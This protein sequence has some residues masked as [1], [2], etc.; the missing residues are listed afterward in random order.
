M[1]PITSWRHM[2]LETIRLVPR[3]REKLEP[4]GFHLWRT[5]SLQLLS[6][7]KHGCND[8]ETN[9]SHCRFLIFFIIS[10]YCHIFLEHLCEKDI[11]W[12][13]HTWTHFDWLIA[14][15]FQEICRVLLMPP[16]TFNSAFLYI[17]YHSMV[18]VQHG[19]CRPNLL[20]ICFLSQPMSQR[21]IPP[22]LDWR[23]PLQS[24]PPHAP[25]DIQCEQCNRSP[26][27]FCFE[28]VIIVTLGEN[29]PL[30]G[31]KKM[32]PNGSTH[33]RKIATKS[34]IHTQD[35]SHA[36][37]A[38]RGMHSRMNV[39]EILGLLQPYTLSSISQRRPCY[40]FQ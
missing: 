34:W 13:H 21:S 32:Q 14:S 16:R 40:G 9:Q 19:S 37:S 33:T 27:F 39:Y 20:K 3:P 24:K 29:L 35:I 22:T 36:C 15:Q 28:C 12:V 26:C 17:S 23:E 30:G 10:M 6:V 38:S 7:R 25:V 11:V 18:F 2:T 31:V 8:A 4:G 1:H 5:R